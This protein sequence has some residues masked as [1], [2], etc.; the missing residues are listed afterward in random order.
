MGPGSRPGLQD[1][2]RPLGLGGGDMGAHVLPAEANEAG[3]SISALQ[4][5]GQDLFQRR[6]GHLNLAT[7]S[8]IPGIVCSCPAWVG[9]KNC[10]RLR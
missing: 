9:W 4:R 6:Q 2:R 7:M 1:D 3:D 10:F 8:M 5:G